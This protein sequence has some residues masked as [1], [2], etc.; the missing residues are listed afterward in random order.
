[1]TT[2]W[3]PTSRRGFGHPAQTI[4]GFLLPCTDEKEGHPMTARELDSQVELPDAPDIPGLAFRP[5]RGEED[6]AVVAAVAMSCTRADG[7]DWFAPH[8]I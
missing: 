2:R 6:F 4:R 7:L 5:L 3:S 1:M 8:V